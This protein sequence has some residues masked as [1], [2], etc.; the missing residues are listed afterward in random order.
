MRT[1]VGAPAPR[2]SVD[3]LLEAVGRMAVS[4][5]VKVKVGIDELR[6]DPAAPA[7]SRHLREH[8]CENP[9]GF[10][11]CEEAMRLFSRMRPE[12]KILI[13]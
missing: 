5:L 8:G 7:F 13:G 4:D 9:D 10:G 1:A 6:D 3:E 2:P 11:S 12:N